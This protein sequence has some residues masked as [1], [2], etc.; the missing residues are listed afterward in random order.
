MRPW[1]GTRCVVGCCVGMPVREGGRRGGTVA[2]RWR[3]TRHR[4]AEAAAGGVWAALPARRRPDGLR[5]R[6]SHCR[7]L[8]PSQPQSGAG[9]GCRGPLWGWRRFGAAVS[10]PARVVSSGVPPGARWCGALQTSRVGGRRASAGR[11]QAAGAGRCSCVG[12]VLARSG[13]AGG[14]AGGPRGAPVGVG[15]L[16]VRSGGRPRRSGR[17]AGLPVRALRGGRGGQRP[18]ACGH[19]ASCSCGCCR[20]GSAVGRGGRAGGGGG[21]GRRPAR[22]PRGAGCGRAPARPPPA[23]RVACSSR[24]DAAAPS[25]PGRA[26]CYGQAVAGSASSSARAGKTRPSHDA[27]PVRRGAPA[28]DHC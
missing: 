19:A 27:H 2:E 10:R 17:S 9:A 5:V 24:R 6:C 22:R 14:G 18:S 23:A 3:R 25:P 21:G 1:C 12:G 28:A 26:P 16:V 15:W 13:R 7:D 4:D 11:R 8:Q 20:R